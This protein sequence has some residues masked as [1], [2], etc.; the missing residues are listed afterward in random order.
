MGE[1]QSWHPRNVTCN[2]VCGTFS[3]TTRR[4]CRTRF[5][6]Y[7]SPGIPPMAWDSNGS[8]AGRSST[9]SGRS[10]RSDRPTGTSSRHAV[11]AG[12]TGTVRWN[13]S[14][15]HMDRSHLVDCSAATTA[16]RGTQWRGRI[17]DATGNGT[18]ADVMGQSADPG[19]D[20]E[21][22]IHPS[23]AD[24]VK[25]RNHTRRLCRIGN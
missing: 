3:K 2:P 21:P 6:P 1:R 18:A 23:Q 25:E 5:Q 22:V 8:R 24:Q 11:V 15:A 17:P 9:N 4:L 12:T 16:C 19:A 14:P 10:L 13:S 20:N 7:V